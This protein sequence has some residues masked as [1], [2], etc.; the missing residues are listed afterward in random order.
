[1]CHVHVS[2]ETVLSLCYCPLCTYSHEEILPYCVLYI[3]IIKKR[4][5]VVKT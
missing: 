5:F 2:I 3:I 1:M 4:Y